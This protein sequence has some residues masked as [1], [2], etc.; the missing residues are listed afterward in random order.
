MEYDLSV[1]LAGAEYLGSGVPYDLDSDEWQHAI[2]A[3]LDDEAV[4]ELFELDD[5]WALV[6]AYARG[7]I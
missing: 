3:P 1:E 7:E 6:R 2:A 5:W 4:T